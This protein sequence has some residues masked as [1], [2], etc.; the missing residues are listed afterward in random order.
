MSELPTLEQMLEFFEPLEYKMAVT[1]HPTAKEKTTNN[2]QPSSKRTQPVKTNSRQTS[3]SS[4]MK[5]TRYFDAQYSSLMMSQR[6]TNMFVSRSGALTVSA[7]DTL[8]A[9][10]LQ[11][12][13]AVTV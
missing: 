13:D 2:H 11:P 3:V 9:T 10:A 1:N 7:V 12:N 8:N 6:R 4:A 5:I